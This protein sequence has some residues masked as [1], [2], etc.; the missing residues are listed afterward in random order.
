MDLSRTGLGYIFSVRDKASTTELVRFE[1]TALAKTIWGIAGRVTVRSRITNARIVAG[2]GAGYV[3]TER[4]SFLDSRSK[5]QF[6]IRLSDLI[7]APPGGA[8]IDW[9]VVVEELVARVM[10]AEHRQPVLRDLSEVAPQPRTPHLFPYLLPDAKATILYGAG[11]TGKSI[12][13]TALAAAIQSG[14]RFLGW[15]TRQR[16][17]LYLDWETDEGDLAHRNAAASRGLGLSKAAAVRYMALELPLE[18]EMA[19]IAAT[20]MENDIGLVV[21]DSV[22]MASSQGRDGSDPAEG[23]INFF[24]ALRML[25]AAV[26]CIDHISG[27]DQ[28]RGRAGASKPYGS[29]FKWNSA[30]NAFELVDASENDGKQKVILRHRKANLGPRMGEFLMGVTWSETGD[31]VRFHREMLAVAEIPLDERILDAL[32]TGPASYRQLA[33]LLNVNGRYEPVTEADLRLAT[34]G[35]IGNTVTVDHAGVLRIAP[36]D[37]KDEGVPDPTIP[38]D[39]DSVTAA[40]AE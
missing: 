38:M 20:V 26:L 29:V 1:V 32:A 23:A 18:M 40:D 19:H 8:A 22:G 33:E 17:V 35:L 31:M 2:V 36:A 39:L 14:A 15:E 30:R 12:L 5:D 16:N 4:L 28:R 27:E 21:I 37:K 3:T 10:D 24:R 13:A 7:P 6:A 25:N 9:Q 11:G 34:R